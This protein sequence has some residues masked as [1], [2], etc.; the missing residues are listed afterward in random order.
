[1]VKRVAIVISELRAG[2]AEQV[3]LHLCSTLRAYGV[4]PVVIC[5][6][7]E[8]ELAKNLVKVGVS[9]IALNSTRSYDFEALFRLARILRQ[10]QPSIIN[11]HDYASLPY[12]VL[13]S[14]LCSKCP[15]VFTAHGLLYEEFEN[16]RWRHRLASLKVSA[17]TAVTQEVAERHRKYLAWTRSISITPNGVPDI[18]CNSD[19]RKRIREELRISSETFVFLAVGNA[20]PEKGFEDLLEASALL[21]ESLPDRPFVVLVAGTIS[22]SPYCQKLLKIQEERSLNKQ[23]RF[24]GYRDDVF[25]LYSAVDALVL[26]SR[27]EGLPMVI[28]EAMTAGLPVIA[29]RV[30][31]V[32]RIVRSDSGLLVRPASPDKLSQAMLKILKNRSLCEKMGQNARKHA[33]QEFT[34]ERMVSK[35]LEVFRMCCRK[36]SGKC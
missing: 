19:E 17:L 7:R 21:R 13:A 11:V 23:V 6:E 34:L 15:I 35:Y 22:S 3:V 24:M 28:L 2:G 20:R 18:P 36:S 12:T 32:P 33:I 26:S 5:L 27:S 16:H 4:A 14:F 25:A 10:W 8:G 30:G 29:T 1:M 9:V 31:G